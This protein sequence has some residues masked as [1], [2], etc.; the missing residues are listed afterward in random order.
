VRVHIASGEIESCWVVDGSCQ[1]AQHF[2]S[3]R[4][5]Q[6]ALAKRER[7]YPERDEFLRLLNMYYEMDQADFEEFEEKC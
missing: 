2:F 7:R 6:Q 3:M 4:E 1:K 5:A